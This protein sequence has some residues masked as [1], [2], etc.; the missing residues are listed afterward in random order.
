MSL[1]NT[2]R[3]VEE[4]KPERECRNERCIIEQVVTVDNRDSVPLGISESWCRTQ[5][6]ELSCLR[7]EG[8]REFICQLPSDTDA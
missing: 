3:G 7:C 8:A 2:G 1:E 5:A 4:L 6:P